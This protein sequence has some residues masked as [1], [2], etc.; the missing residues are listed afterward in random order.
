MSVGLF[1]EHLLPHLTKADLEIHKML[2]DVAGAVGKAS[3]GKQRPVCDQISKPCPQFLFLIRP[4]T[5]RS[6]EP[7]AALPLFSFCLFLR[8]MFL[9]VNTSARLNTYLFIYQSIAMLE[10]LSALYDSF[11]CTCRGSSL[12]QTH[13]LIV[14]LQFVESS[15][16]V[17]AYLFKGTVTKSG[18][19]RLP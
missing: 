7:V 6:R 4:R 14:L 2:R 1:T 10:Y 15:V 17:P 3:K 5:M 11:V 13:I 18:K 16:Y 12:A 19:V 8:F 9:P